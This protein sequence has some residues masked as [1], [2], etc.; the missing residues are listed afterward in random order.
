MRT[1]RY[2]QPKSQGSLSNNLTLSKARGFF[3]EANDNI[4]MKH[5]YKITPVHRAID[6]K[7]VVNKEHCDKKLTVFF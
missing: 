6:E 3:L 5:T 7:D 2:N 4:D 1:N